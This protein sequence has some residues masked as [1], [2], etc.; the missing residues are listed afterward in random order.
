MSQIPVDESTSLNE[1]QLFVSIEKVVQE[2]GF[3]CRMALYMLRV[4]A[5]E[6]WHVNVVADRSH[7]RCAGETILFLPGRSTVPT[8]LPPRLLSLS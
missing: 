6:F 4:A 3:I 5:I 7:M 1:A 8:R 2:S